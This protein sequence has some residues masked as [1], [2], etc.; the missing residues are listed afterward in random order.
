V[1]PFAYPIV[2]PMKSALYIDTAEG[3]GQWTVV[4][5][6][7]T[8]NFLRSTHKK[9]ISTFNVTVKKIKELSCGHFTHNN[10]KRLSGSATEVPVFEAKVSRNLRLVYQ[11]DIIPG[12]YVHVLE[13]IKIFG[14][15]THD[16]IDNCLWRSISDQL[17][18]KGA[19][20]RKRCAVR[21]RADQ[22]SKDTFIPVFFSPR[23]EVSLSEIENI[24]DL[25]PDG[26]AQVDLSFSFL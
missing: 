26:A 7:D 6:S 4:V 22:A 3:F 18:K 15:Y 25:R 24:L 8:D 12:V 5:S 1:E 23:P 2:Q 20:Y 11:I 17:H 10:Q 16:Q 21:K 14:I 13:A 9:D 19:E